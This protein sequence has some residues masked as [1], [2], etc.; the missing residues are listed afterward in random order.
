MIR[1]HDSN[2]KEEGIDYVVSPFTEYMYDHN[3]R[4]EKD[5]DPEHREAYRVQNEKMLSQASAFDSRNVN[6]E[7]LFY[8]LTSAYGFLSSLN[9][10]SGFVKSLLYGLTQPTSIIAS[11]HSPLATKK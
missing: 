8:T 11:Q 9:K 3:L 5:I 1:L 2:K 4:A 7:V 10:G 6:S